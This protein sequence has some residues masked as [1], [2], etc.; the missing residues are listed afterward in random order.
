VKKGTWKR[1]KAAT[2]K[3]TPEVPVP[4]PADPPTHGEVL[5][6]VESSTPG[7]PLA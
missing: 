6:A 7:D 3:K 2:K 4:V 1:A 5:E